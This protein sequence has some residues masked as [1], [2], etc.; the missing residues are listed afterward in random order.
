MP[1][2]MIYRFMHNMYYAN[3]QVLTDEIVTRQGATPPLS[4]FCIER[5]AVNDV[6]FTAAETLG[7]STAYW[8]SGIRL[9]W[10]EIVDKSGRNLTGPISPT[11]SARTL[12]ITHP[13]P[14]CAHSEKK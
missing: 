2:L 13:L 14:C 10:C 9:V 3:S 7:G 11:C 8:R 12:Y 4:W 6:D 1:G 5:P